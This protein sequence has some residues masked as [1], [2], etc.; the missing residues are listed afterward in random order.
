V[1]EHPSLEWLVPDLLQR[2]RRSCDILGK[3]LLGRLIQDANA[4]VYT[5]TRVPPRK[6]VLSEILIQK[7]SLDQQFDNPTSE[8]FCH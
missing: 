4:V 5:E 8:Y 6:K 2:Y 7:L 1:K 3:V